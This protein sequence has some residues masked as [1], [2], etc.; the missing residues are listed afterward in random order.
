VKKSWA[1]GTGVEARAR[2]LQVGKGSYG[3]VI[4]VRKYDNRK[5]YAL[6]ASLPPFPLSRLARQRRAAGLIGAA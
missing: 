5:I 3:K 4:Q 6:K 2:G 1:V